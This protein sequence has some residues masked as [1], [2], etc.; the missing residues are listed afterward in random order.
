MRSVRRLYSEH[1][2]EKLVESCDCKIWSWVPRDTEPR[3]TVQAR[4]S[5][6]LPDKWDKLIVSQQF[7]TSCDMAASRQRLKRESRRI[8]IVW[9]RNLSTS[10]ENKLRR[11]VVCCE[12]SRALW[13]LVLR[14]YKSSINTITSPN[15]G[16]VTSAW[17]YIYKP[18]VFLLLQLQSCRYRRVLF[19]TS[20]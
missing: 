5:N 14:T 18:F 20:L 17:Q 2:R 16:L 11:L 9:S 15:P 6:K 3:M 1:E 19:S 13:L 8:S 10:S 7:R 12:N 4:A